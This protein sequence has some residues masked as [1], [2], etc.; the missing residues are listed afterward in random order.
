M[1]RPALVVAGRPASLLA[2]ALP[3]LV[4]CLFATPAAAQPTPAATPRPAAPSAISTTSGP[5]WSQLSNEQRASLAPLQRDW[6]AIDGARKQKWLE[7]AA[8]FPKM[9]ADER[10]RVQERMAEWAR[11][12]PQDRSAARLGFQQAQRVAPQDR[13]AKWDAYQALPPDQRRQLA[14]SSAAAYPAQ[15]GAEVRS[16]RDG[17]QLKSN[18][19]PNPS[20]AAPLKPVAPTVVQAQPGASTRLMSRPSVPPAHQQTGLPKI[21]ASPGFVDRATLLPQRGPQG[22]ATRSA[23]AASPEPAERTEHK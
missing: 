2:L 17:V 8:K 15:R 23:K 10:Q 12:S 6:P 14:A 7:V 4:A 9:P 21:A 1:F 13:Q 19:V 20:Y 22:A 5:A 11:M 18:I 3:L 16:G